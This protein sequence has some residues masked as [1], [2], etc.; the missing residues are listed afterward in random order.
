MPTT[1][2]AWGLYI[3]SAAMHVLDLGESAPAWKPMPALPEA[4]THFALGNV[5]DLLTAMGGMST[6]RAERGY[7]PRTV[8]KETAVLDLSA[9]QNGW[10]VQASAPNP[11]R[12]WSATA[13]CRGKLWV[14]GGLSLSESGTEK[15]EGPLAR[16]LKLRPSIRH[17]DQ[18]YSRS[19]GDLLGWG[20]AAY[21]DRY[22]ILVGGHGGPKDVK[23]RMNVIP[24]VYDTMEDR[25]LRLEQSVT[26]AGGDFNDPGV[27]ICQD[28][29]YV[30][31]AEGN[32]GSHFNHWLIGR[33]ER[34]N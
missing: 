21:L 31:G 19:R 20:G 23:P 26:P 12:G 5:G 8:R 10:T 29:I 9:P 15:P 1:V 24:L 16:N 4:R 17:M 34:S 3:P 30:A 7:S 13:A 28:A 14:F 25:W 6:M 32:G 33:I 2:T 11:A 22:V 27:A 18:A